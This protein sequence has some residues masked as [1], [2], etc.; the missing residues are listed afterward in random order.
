MNT[1]PYQES[2][3]IIA[4]PKR[5]GAA[6]RRDWRGANVVD[7]APYR[8]LADYGEGWYHAAAIAEDSDRKD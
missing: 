6:A 8:P 4:F 2:A 5:L 3:K 1:G 7:L